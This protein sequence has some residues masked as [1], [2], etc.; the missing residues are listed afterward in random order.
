MKY[1]TSSNNT[2]ISLKALLA[3]EMNDQELPAAHG[4]PLRAI[5]PGH[6]GVR[7]VKWVNKIVLSDQESEG[8][9]QRGF[10]PAPSH[11]QCEPIRHV[12]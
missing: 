9:W 3:Y 8:P 5:V 4:Y 11:S 6:V 2:F 10:N 7:N 12:L 1:K